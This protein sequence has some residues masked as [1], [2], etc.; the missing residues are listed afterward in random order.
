MS[1][2]T[3][4]QITATVSD[5]AA[6]AGRTTPPTLLPETTVMSAHIE[7]LADRIEAAI[8]GARADL[9]LAP[10]D[11]TERQE[12]LTAIA[13]LNEKLKGIS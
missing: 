5:L 9:G 13:I 11:Y 3:A 2:L 12:I 1:Y 4:L 8:V 6:K 7:A 10:G